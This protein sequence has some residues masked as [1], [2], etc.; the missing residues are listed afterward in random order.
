MKCLFHISLLTTLSPNGKIC[1][2]AHHA[3]YK[4]TDAVA[5]RSYFSILHIGILITKYKVWNLRLLLAF[6]KFGTAPQF[7]CDNLKKRAAWDDSFNVG[8]STNRWIGNSHTI[9]QCC[10][11]QIGFRIIQLPCDCTNF[12][13]RPNRSRS[14]GLNRSRSGCGLTV[15]DI[16]ATQYEQRMM[17]S[18]K[19][20][21]K[22]LPY[23]V[24]V[25]MRSPNA[26]YHHH[27]PTQLCQH[28]D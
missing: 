8:F 4:N 12:G 5:S 20:T 3:I 27:P 1:K 24:T 16:K 14:C 25:P 22:A 28:I 19:N 6:D 17:Q 9:G 15:K 7:K 11:S 18:A 13:G 21:T 26:H 23:T 10:N 2:R